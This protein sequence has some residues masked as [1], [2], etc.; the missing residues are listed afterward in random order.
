MKSLLAL[1][2]C[3]LHQCFQAQYLAIS[4]QIGGGGQL[5]SAISA[6]K[7]ISTQLSTQFLGAYVSACMQ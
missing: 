4:G 6:L 3:Y 2:E 7:K 1:V 5:P